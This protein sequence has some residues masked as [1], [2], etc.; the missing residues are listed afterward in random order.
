MIKQG[1]NKNSILSLDYT[2]WRATPFITWLLPGLPSGFPAHN[3]YDRPAISAPAR[4]ATARAGR[5]RFL[6][7]Y[8]DTRRIESPSVPVQ[9]MHNESFGYYCDS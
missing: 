5:N 2:A 4:D 7:M 3:V 6:W 8:D 1:L 9:G